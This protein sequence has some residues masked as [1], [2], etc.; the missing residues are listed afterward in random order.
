MLQNKDIDKRDEGESGPPSRAETHRSQRP[1]AMHLCRHTSRPCLV[2]KATL[3]A[4]L[5][6]LIVRNVPNVRKAVRWNSPFYGIEGLGWF[7]S[8][9]VFTRYVRL[10]FFQGA[11]LQPVPAGA[12]KDKDGALD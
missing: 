7:L 4:R 1:M 8:Y 2:G 11:S 12:G 3:G 6:A 10:T 9:H 5:D